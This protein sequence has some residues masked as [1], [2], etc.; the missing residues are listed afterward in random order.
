MPFYLKVFVGATPTLSTLASAAI[1][2]NCYNFGGALFIPFRGV[3]W[4]IAALRHCLAEA[5]HPRISLI[6]PLVRNF[7]FWW[8]VDDTTLRA[9]SHGQ[10]RAVVYGEYAST[11]VK[12][13]NTS[14]FSTWTSSLILPFGI[15]IFPSNPMSGAP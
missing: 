7:T 15:T 6:R 9:C 11:I 1:S 13:T 2:I 12:S 3:R 10:A 5:W 4:L 14:F 8:R